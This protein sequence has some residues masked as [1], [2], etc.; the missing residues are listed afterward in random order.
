MDKFRGPEMYIAICKYQTHEKVRF[1]SDRLAAQPRSKGLRKCLKGIA[2]QCVPNG[3][4]QNIFFMHYIVRPCLTDNRIGP[5][6]CRHVVI[7]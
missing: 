1:F 3:S 5:P 7:Q 4:A 2:K 6:R